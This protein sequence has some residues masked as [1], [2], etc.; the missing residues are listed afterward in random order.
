[1]KKILIFMIPFLILTGCGKKETGLTTYTKDV[2]KKYV[3]QNEKVEKALTDVV[4]G[5]NNLKEFESLRKLN[6]YTLET[7][8]GLTN[9]EIE[10]YIAA[11]P[12]WVDT[13]MY[14]ILKPVKG[15]EE[16]VKRMMKNYLDNYKYQLENIGLSEEELNNKIKLFDE[17]VEKEE[18]GYL[19]YIISSDS[20]Q[21]YTQ[22]KKEI[23]KLK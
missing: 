11:V 4:I 23:S 9:K 18:N 13:R 5:E 21:I 10:N 17:R 2:N 14:V 22:I 7:E 6:D 12:D 1:M 19:I 3:E 8:F 16:K 15:N 20:N